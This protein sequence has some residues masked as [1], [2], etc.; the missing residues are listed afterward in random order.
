M[1]KFVD[2]LKK[3]P[4]LNCFIAIF[5]SMVAI[6]SIP[7]ETYVQMCILRMLLCGTLFFLL[8]F[9][10][11]DKTINSCGN[12]TGYVIKVA[13]AIWL[14]ALPLGLLGLVAQ[15]AEAETIRPDWPYQLFTIF[16]LFVFVGLFE[17]LAFRAIIN[18]AL[19]YRFRDKKNVFLWIAIVSSLVFG[20]AHIFGY[21]LMTPLDWVQAVGKTLSAGVFGLCTLILYWHTRNVWACGLVHGIYDFI[22]GFSAAFTDSSMSA[23][24]VVP[25]EHAVLAIIVYAVSVLVMLIPLGIIWKKVGKKIDFDEIRRT[26]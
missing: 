15:L 14:L 5:F 11:G 9:I 20:A 6:K 18:D 13:V 1:K 4:L 10:S 19:L 25:E 24:Y 23:S 16:L 26:W 22:V 3:Y 7:T 17:E 21:V 8:S 12:S 2:L